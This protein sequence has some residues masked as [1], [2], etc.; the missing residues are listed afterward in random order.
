MRRHA[1]I[2]AFLVVLALPVLLVLASP[3]AH[4]AD[5]PTLGLRYPS[6]TPDNER[7]VFGY[8]GDIWIARADGKGPATRLTMHEAQET[9]PRVSPDGKQVAFSSRRNGGYDLFVTSVDGGLPKQL[10]F[11]GGPAILSSWSPDGKRLLFLGSRGPKV[12]GMDLYEVDLAGGT[13]RAVTTDGGRDGAYHPNG[14][15]IVYARGFNTIYQDNYEGAANYDL[16]VVDEPGALPRRLTQTG[17][18]ERYP[19]YSKDGETI[20]FVAEEKG[21]AGFY[22][23]PAAGGERRKVVSFKDDVW[24]PCPAW[25]GKSVAFEMAGHVYKTDVTAKEPKATQLPITVKSDV[26]HSGRH[27]RRIT[28]GPEQ[29]HVSPDGTRVAFA[30]HG[31]IWMMPAS[32]GEGTRLTSD[33]A[34]EDWPRFSP[35]GRSIAY[36]S[37]KGGS[38]NLY[39]LDLKTRKSRQLTNHKANDFFHAWSPDGRK[40]IFTSERSGNR[41]IWRLDLESGAVDQLTR[42]PSPDDDATYS[43]DGRWI[44]FDSGREGNQA[45]FV[46]PAEGGRARRIS[47]GTGFFQVPSYAPDSSM[48]VFE[49]YNPATGRSGGL[50]VT[51]ANGGPQVQLTRSGSAAHWS[52]KGD[53]IFYTVRDND[54]RSTIHR[55]PAPRSIDQSE[56]VPFSGKIEVDRRTELGDL[57]DEAWGRLKDGFYDPKMHGVDWNAMKKRYRPI[58]V[59][60]ED[61]SEFH[62]V[63]RQMLAELG[64]SHLGIS[65][66]DDGGEG[67]VR[68]KLVETGLLGLE[69][70]HER[71]KD[72]WRVAAVTPGGP[73]DKTGVRIGDVVTRIGSTKLGAK[74]N[75]DKVLAGKAGKDISIRFKPVTAQGLGDERKQV[76]RPAAW[77]DMWNLGYQNWL[78]QSA[79]AV[80]EGTKGKAGYIHLSMMNGENLQKFQKA[81]AKWNRDP[82]IKGMV[83]DVRNNGGGNIHV[84]LMDILTSRPFMQLKPRTGDK[85][86]QP[87]L[88]WDKPVVVLINERSFSDAEVFPH[89]FRYAGV[90]KLVGAPTAGGVIGTNDITLSDGSRLRIPRVGWWGM[91][92]ESL[93]GTGVQPDI[94]VLETSEDRR[95]GRDRQMAKALEVIR[96]E[97]KEY[98]AA[99]KAK[100]K[101]KKDAAAASAANAKETKPAVS[102][103]ATPRLKPASALEPLADAVAGEWVR[104]RLSFGGQTTLLKVDVASAT[105]EKVT[106]A[107]TVE[108]GGEF[109]PP[110]PEALTRGPILESL[111]GLGKVTAHEVTRS[112]LLEKEIEVLR[113]HLTWEGTPLVL[114]FTNA[115]PAMGLLSVEADG[116]TLM[117]AIAWHPATPVEVKAE[118]EPQPKAAE[119]AGPN[120]VVGEDAEDTEDAPSAPLENPLY[121]AEVGEW[122]RM[123]ITTPGGEATITREVIEVTDDEVVSRTFIQQG[124]RRADGP[125]M[126]RPR[127]KAFPFGERG[128]VTWSSEEVEIN[129]T[130]L[131]CH[132]ATM[133]RRG[134]EI[135]RWIS[136]QVPVDGLVRLE[137]G[138]EIVSEL[139]EWGSDGAPED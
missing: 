56:V 93:E 1:P 73:A 132:V 76:I 38:S 57:F 138:G 67:Y 98:E 44:A 110:I 30:V 18:N 60:A 7:V 61:K 82:K 101:A 63:I 12:T 69:F 137:R 102:T 85:I 106:F 59:D 113:A 64:A 50:Y 52:P 19:F 41:D 124:E 45:V 104:Y 68:P 96:A 70:A 51:S 47:Q 25:D 36:Q 125:T 90:G 116:E 42:H 15:T 28:T 43:P 53:Y 79:E 13:P 99:E 91:D 95:Q 14:K 92:G 24:R 126:R 121:D 123:R 27:V 65:G 87:G 16:F 81:V 86:T 62:N 78:K 74:T 109:L 32:G 29:V 133:T 103:P 77:R 130:T 37:D 111:A 117:E 127:T 114:T 48:L 54:G 31:D 66:G 88:Y 119:P 9:L 94:L 105:D 84:Q 22:A 83:L 122:V 97:I 6:L 34:Q 107:Q 131:A 100:A 134:A 118:P 80:K 108:E 58:A 2:L 71:T 115:I 5:K 128:P 75:I 20:Y 72:G 112:T 17:G 55:H 89:A 23:M 39:L 139:L 46:M 49:A 135:R 21:I 35:D 11:H 8:R 136:L 3:G 129:G 33:K 120:P 26:R 10:T 4:A 40:L